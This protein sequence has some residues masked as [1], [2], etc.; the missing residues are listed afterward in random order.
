MSYWTKAEWDERKRLYGRALEIMGKLE[1]LGVLQPRELRKFRK[2][3]LAAHEQ[4]RKLW[5]KSPEYRQQAQVHQESLK[6]L[7]GADPDVA[8]ML[9]SPKVWKETGAES[10]ATVRNLAGAYK[11]VLMSDLTGEDLTDPG[12]HAV[13]S[14]VR[15]K[16]LEYLGAKYFSG[17]EMEDQD[18]FTIQQL[19]ERLASGQ[20]TPEDQE[21]LGRYESALR[22]VHIGAAP[23]MVAKLGV[24]KGLGYGGLGVTE[25]A[26][27]GTRQIN[28]MGEGQSYTLPHLAEDVLTMGGGPLLRGAAAPVARGIA[29]VPGGKAALQRLSPGWAPAT[30][31]QAFRAGVQE[32]FVAPAR[33]GME[34]VFDAAWPRMAPQG[35]RQIPPNTVRQGGQALDELTAQKAMDLRF[36]KRAAFEQLQGQP[37]VSDLVTPAYPPKPAALLPP[38]PEAR[39]DSRFLYGGDVRAGATEPPPPLVEP[40]RVTLDPQEGVPVLLPPKPPPVPEG[41]PSAFRVEDR[42]AGGADREVHPWAPPEEVTPESAMETLEAAAAARRKTKMERIEE[43]LER[44]AAKGARRDS[45]LLLEQRLAQ[46]AKKAP[47]DPSDLLEKRIKRALKKVQ[48][49]DS[50]IIET[51]DMSPQPPP[52]KTPKLSEP[53][54]REVVQVLTQEASDLPKSSPVRENVAFVGKLVEDLVSP[55]RDA[56]PAVASAK[57]AVLNFGDYL[58]DVGPSGRELVREVLRATVRAEE[59][60][61]N[62]WQPMK[63]VLEGLTPEEKQAFIKAAETPLKDTPERIFREIVRMADDRNLPKE[64]RDLALTSVQRAVQGAEVAERSLDEVLKTLVPPVRKA[65]QVWEQTRAVMTAELALVGAFRNVSDESARNIILGY[66]PHKMTPY[67]DRLF[68][69][70]RTDGTVPARFQRDFDALVDV[71]VESLRKMKKFAKKT[72]GELREEAALRLA[73]TAQTE[74][75]AE[76]VMDLVRGQ[77]LRYRFRRTWNFPS[78]APSGEQ[79]WDTDPL[80]ALRS[81]IKNTEKYLSVTRDYGPNPYDLKKSPLGALVRNAEAEIAATHSSARLRKHVTDT[82]YRGIQAALTREPDTSPWARETMALGSLLML[83]LAGFANLTQ[84]ILTGAKFGFS[85]ALRAQASELQGT[86]RAINDPKARRMILDLRDYSGLTS[87]DVVG[88][89]ADLQGGG[90]GPLEKLAKSR[91]GRPLLLMPISKS[92]VEHAALTALHG[93]ADQFKALTQGTP[94]Q[95]ATASQVLQ[96][97]YDL[98][99][100]DIRI[101][102]NHYRRFWELE[103]WAKQEGVRQEVWDWSFKHI[104][105]TSPDDLKQGANRFIRTYDVPDHLVD[106]LEAV[107]GWLVGRQLSPVQHR[108]VA[109]NS[110]LITQ[111]LRINPLARPAWLGINDPKGAHRALAQFMSFPLGMVSMA[112][113]MMKENPARAAK[114][115]PATLLAGWLNVKMKEA[116][117]DRPGP[118]FDESS[119]LATV[120]KGAYYAGQGGLFGPFTSYNP[121]NWINLAG[122][123]GMP[124]VE[125]GTRM[126]RVLSDQEKSWTEKGLDLATYIPKV[127]ALTPRLKPEGVRADEQVAKEAR[128]YREPREIRPIAADVWLGASG[129]AGKDPEKTLRDALESG[130]PPAALER[131]VLGTL[132]SKLPGVSLPPDRRLVWARESQDAV[133]ALRSLPPRYAKAVVALKVSGAADAKGIMSFLRS[134]DR[135]EE[136]AI[137][138]SRS[139]ERNRDLYGDTF[140]SPEKIESLIVA[141][142]VL[143]QRAFGDQSS[144]LDEVL[145]EAAKLDDDFAALR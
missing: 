30:A 118:R 101:A 100:E 80:R 33:A 120:K 12:D 55:T 135:G 38:P 62:R 56:N 47:Q 85:P 11:R 25:T 54:V 52:P 103:K 65:L 98:S 68:R 83:Q 129:M 9:L 24:L 93:A 117:T 96:K 35:M 8:K 1:D 23:A 82:M 87:E 61:N 90:R 137:R 136:A 22:G 40:P 20:G 51:P 115:I 34:K 109:A 106:D 44:A 130:V 112:Y 27:L 32:E 6:A 92:N 3:F 143:D 57:L 64:L 94:R 50:A 88:L 29:K 70:I 77:P 131:A 63:A 26:L 132:R 45:D 145:N 116:V 97:R 31:G 105:S 60:G 126:M 17:D 75:P 21:K 144:L 14:Q 95:R 42:R 123:T 140:D 84:R 53:E 139:L 113:G 5:K 86:F 37:M 59:R 81:H 49:D 91:V 127:G 102:E 99:M 104:P 141:L 124:P 128:A 111:M 74:N 36:A 78:H 138:M 19:K 89:M 16:T 13:V 142:Q 7:E 2:D 79:L 18:P 72:D 122:M 48:Q 10:V 121:D 43:R 15:D 108:M 125:A 69:S 46:A 76:D 67:A 110:A 58:K 41:P 71:V 28:R 134:L 107:G 133:E 114:L 4:N 39:K 119:P 73:K 66:F